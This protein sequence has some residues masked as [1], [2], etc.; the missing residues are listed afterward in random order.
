MKA[1][2]H[3]EQKKHYPL[4]FLVNGVFRPN[5][6]MP[7]R[8]DRLLQGALAAGCTP[9]VS[10]NHGIAPI[11]EIHCGAY[12]EFLEHAWERWQRIDGA[13]AAVTPN[14]HPHR[15]NTG[16]PASVVAQAGYHMADAAVPIADHSWLS[17]CRSAWAAVHAAKL[18]LAGDHS[19]YALCRPPGHHA[20]HDMG[21]G[22]CYLNNSAIGAQVLRG[23]YDRVAILD[24]DLHHGNGTQSIFYARDDVLTVS[25][26]ADPLRFYPFF[27]GY[28]N[29]RGKGRGEGFN[30]NLPLPRG[31]GDREFIE[32]LSMG[33]ERIRDFAPGALVIAL[34]LDAFEGD[35]FGGLCISTR[36]FGE[37][38]AAIARSLPLP[39]LV[40]QEGGYLCD[41]L[42]DN[43]T[44]FLRG[45]MQE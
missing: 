6:E 4:Q 8:L 32:A 27:W 35:P 19:A 11:R 16:Y 45:F 12:L 24:I 20:F 28:A 41:E 14:I 18:I 1:V 7:E 25:L 15:R 29:E 34:G 10:E 30:L 40:V 37:I 38:G 42:G 17:S 43:L 2:Y 33:L 39:T 23:T 31:S 5:P 44:C 3:V 13:A 22:F 9:E 26:H 36:G 21:G